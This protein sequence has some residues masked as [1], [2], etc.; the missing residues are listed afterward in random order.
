M[1][2]PVPMDKTVD[3]V[4]MARTEAEAHQDVIPITSASEAAPGRAVTARPPIV[5]FKVAAVVELEM[6]PMVPAD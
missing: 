6:P 5:A 2:A 1:A 3:V 4:Q